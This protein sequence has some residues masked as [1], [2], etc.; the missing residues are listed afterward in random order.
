MKEIK[1]ATTSFK[2]QF[3]ITPLDKTVRLENVITRVKTYNI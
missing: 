2:Q 1:R 3:H